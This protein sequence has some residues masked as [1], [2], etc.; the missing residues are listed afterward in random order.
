MGKPIKI[1]Q[2]PL[3]PQVTWEPL[4]KLGLYFLGPIDPP[5]NQK[6]YI[7]TCTDYLTKWVKVKALKSEN[8]EAV[9]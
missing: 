4:D 6:N 5:S 9:A 8:E 7:L 2:M 3:T 1:D